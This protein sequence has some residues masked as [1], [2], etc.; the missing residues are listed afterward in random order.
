MIRT[1]VTPCDNMISI[2]VPVDY[3]GKKLEVLLYAFE[4]VI[5]E[6][7]HFTCGH[8][9][10]RFKGLLTDNEADKYHQYLQRARQEWDRSI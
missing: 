9:A 1:V 10:S 2:P 6:T 7:N 3:I 5:E 4:E 8:S